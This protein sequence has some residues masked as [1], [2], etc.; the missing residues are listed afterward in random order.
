MSGSIPKIVKKSGQLFIYWMTYLGFYVSNLSFVSNYLRRAQECG[1]AMFEEV[2][3]AMLHNAEYG[4]PRAMASYR[5]ERSNALFHRSIKAIDQAKGDML[6]VRFLEK[7]RDR[8]RE[9]MRSEMQ[10][11][12][13]EEIFFRSQP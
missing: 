9:M 6:V 4:P 7:L 10:Q 11:A 1:D 13:E 5:G 3:R 2:E 8:G 12:E